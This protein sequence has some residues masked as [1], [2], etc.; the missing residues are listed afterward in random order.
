MAKFTES[1]LIRLIDIL[2]I[3]EYNELNNWL[4]LQNLKT[5][6]KIKSL[7][8]ELKKY[9]K[10]PKNGLPS[11]QYLFKKLYPQNNNYKAN[12]L[13]NLIRKFTSLIEVFIVYKESLSE[14]T[15]SF[16]YFRGLLKK[17]ESNIFFKEINQYIS[18]LKN[19]KK[20]KLPDSILLFQ[21]YQLLYSHP[22][23][24]QKYDRSGD[25]IVR[26]NYYLEHFFL[27]Q[28]YTLLHEMDAATLSKNSDNCSQELDCLKFYRDQSDSIIVKLFE[29]RSLRSDTITNKDFDEFY[30]NYLRDYDNLP[31]T[32]QR[33]FLLLC[34]NDAIRL[35]VDGQYSKIG[36]KLFNLYNFGINEGLIFTKSSVTPMMFNNLVTIALQ[37][38][39]I[40]FIKGFLWKRSL[41]LPNSW[42]QDAVT[43]AQAKL[44]YELDQ[45][46]RVIDL[47]VNHNWQNWLYKF[48]QRV[49]L[50]QAYFDLVHSNHYKLTTF[51]SHLS[52]FKV[53]VHRNKKQYRFHPETYLNLIKFSKEVL[54][55]LSTPSDDKAKQREKIK[56]KIESTRLLFGRSWL[57]NKLLGN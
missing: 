35:S 8:R 5:P 55:F 45:H 32:Y 46:T 10:N 34:V 4:D 1:K 57:L 20:G 23:Y 30:D 36:Q 39:E 16:L 44:A 40:D 41:Y 19:H 29:Q 12:Y 13:N 2:S 28:K 31:E 6:K 43:W 48:Q 22:A 11:K 25:H 49:V 18:D 21:L 27:E 26:Q 38:K 51:T 47:V 42:S 14:E 33:I 17:G 9:R 37:L 56:E 53:F 50:L 24:Q 15:R 54:I 52:S 3:T 7:Y